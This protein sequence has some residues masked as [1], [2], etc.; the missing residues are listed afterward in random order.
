MFQFFFVDFREREKHLFVII[1][2]YAF[3]GCF[4]Y[5]PWPEIEP[6]K[7]AYQDD[8]LTNLATWQGQ[9]VPI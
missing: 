7:L 5:V 3:I 6:T 2:T 4:F 8:T 1:L 9:D